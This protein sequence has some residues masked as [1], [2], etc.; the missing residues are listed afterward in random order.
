[1]TTY[2]ELDPRSAIEAAR[3]RSERGAEWS[4]E[5]HSIAMLPHA[6]AY[7]RRGWFVYPVYWCVAPWVCACKSADKCSDPVKHPLTPGGGKDATVNPDIISEWWS[8]WPTANIGIACGRISNFLALDVDG[9]EGGKSIHALMAKHGRPAPTVVSVTG[10]GGRHILWAY[11]EGVQ[12]LVRVAPG[13]DV[14]SDGGCIVAPPSLHASGGRYEWH[15]QGH[16]ARVKLQHSPGWL[17]EMLR[18]PKPHREQRPYDPNRPKPQIDL[19]RV[20]SITEGERNRALYKLACRMR[21]EG[22]ND[23][24][25]RNGLA[26]VNAHKVSPPVDDRELYK[27]ARSACRFA[28][29]S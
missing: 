22:R 24:E 7:A 8:R 19:E 13:L 16:P 29:G 10:G 2:E 25:V 27:I 20:P 23:T 14:R 21:W 1:M 5:L 17:L 18:R 28:P 12:N 26:Y 3:A 4:A 11:A 6:R 9:E 15:E